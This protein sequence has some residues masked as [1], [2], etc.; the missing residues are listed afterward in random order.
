MRVINTK[1]IDIKSWANDIEDGALHQACNLAS[2][3]FAYKHIALMPDVHEGFGMPIG[4]VLAAAEMIIPNGVGVDI[5]CGVLAVKTDAFEAKKKDLIEIINRATSKIPLGFK[6]HKK[7]QDWPGFDSSPQIPIIKREL[8]SARYQLGTLG[9]G[10]H[11]CSIEKGCDGHL[12]IMI[13]SGSRNLGYKVANEYN[14]IAKLTNKKLSLVPESFDLAC[15]EVKS[16]EGQEYIAAMNFCLEFAKANRIKLF[17][18]FYEIFRQVLGAEKI[19]KQIDIHHNYA[20][21]ECH[22]G[23]DVIIHRKGAIKAGIGQEGIIPGSMGTP[24]YIVEGLGN[25]DSFISCSHG[26]GRRMSRK[27]ANDYL[28][29]DMASKSM[30]GIIFSGWKG[31]LSEAP[32]AYKDIE[33]VMKNQCDLVKPIVKLRPL[34]VMKG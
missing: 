10:N 28:T 9:G 13:H 24:S 16:P 17:N 18:D 7:P 22:F 26:A 29:E 5:G 32:M 20:A 6:H 3:P 2:L 30:E 19:I 31:D 15:L 21:E 12:W 33:E 8:E 1:G 14:K 23:R 25:H 34:A 4:G 27:K 11:F